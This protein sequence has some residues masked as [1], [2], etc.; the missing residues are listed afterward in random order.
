MYSQL[1]A[2]GIKPIS[3]KS[4]L[5]SQPHAP[6]FAATHSC[7]YFFLPFLEQMR[8]ELQLSGAKI[9]KANFVFSFNT[10]M[11]LKDS[12]TLRLLGLLKSAMRQMRVCSI[13]QQAAL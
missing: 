10:G 3:R 5:F 11:A 4:C 9:L 6:I 2:H 7:C 8:T 13:L 12:Q 1:T